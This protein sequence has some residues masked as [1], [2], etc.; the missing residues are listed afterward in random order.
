MLAYA[1]AG[2]RSAALQQYRQCARVLDDELGVAPLPETTELAELIR[3]NRALPPPVLPA[4]PFPEDQPDIA[5]SAKAPLVG[6]G[7]EWQSI[8]E[9]YATAT[10][11]GC[12]IVL[13]GEPGIGKTRLAEEFINY[14]RSRDAIVLEGRC[15]EGESDLAYGVSGD[16]IRAALEDPLASGRLECVPANWLAE[17]ARLLP[18][19]AQHRPDLP[20]PL[21]DENG[22]GARLVEGLRRVIIAL[23]HGHV[24]GV[25]F[26]DD[27]QWADDASLELLQHVIRHF[28]DCPLLVLATWRDEEGPVS[29]R[30]RRLVG[31]ARRSGTA[32]ILALERLQPEQIV[33][34]VST[35]IG[36]SVVAPDLAVRLHEQTE[37]LPL[38]LV[39]CLES[40]ADHSAALDAVPAGMRDLLR[41][42]V[43][44]LNETAR[45]LL[46]AAA[47]VGHSFDFDTLREASGRTT[48]ETTTALDELLS[49]R[50]VREADAG[51]FGVRFDFTHEQLRKTMYEDM[52]L[53]RRRLLHRRVAEALR[54]GSGSS[55]PVEREPGEIAVHFR[56]GGQEALAAEYYV[57]AGER[58]QRLHANAEALAHFEAALALGYSDTIRLHEAIGD[59]HTLSGAY[60]LAASSYD[61]AAS[62]ALPDSLVVLER[63]L[64]RLCVRQGA[65]E[66]AESHFRAALSHSDQTDIAECAHLLAAWSLAAFRQDQLE[67]AWRLATE[68]LQTAELA[69]DPRALAECH[70]V[71]GMLARHRGDAVA[72]EHHLERSLELATANDDHCGRIAALNNL[73]LLHAVTGQSARGLESLDVALDVCTLLGDHHLQAA[74]LTNSADMLR[75]TGDLEGAV[76]RMKEAAAILADIGAELGS[77]Q[78]EIW[79][80]SEW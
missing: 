59:L 66:R 40:L 73:A 18:E 74:L 30:L 14:I 7:R 1:C 34:L 44:S 32:T 11:H 6:R 76:A 43:E 9:A 38:F 21:A 72:A 25:L 28:R 54:A 36:A 49:R 50:M 41:A 56:F 15:Y 65:W 3:A 24:P 13:E 61:L 52:S 4:R 19:L 45:Q 51:S 10:T 8:L 80:L 33:E 5:S 75:A 47:V 23:V 55:S 16:V 67:R 2:E 42:R 46:G 58:A 22:A 17:A 35:H 68:A 71:V 29:G 77:L 12:L 20:R 60:G 37:G 62:G 70:N 31:D 69:D 53:I 63:K 27:L 79:K 48:D 64:G 26:I 78:P 39:M 57:R